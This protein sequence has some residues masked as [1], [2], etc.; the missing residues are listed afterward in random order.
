MTDCITR[1][2]FARFGFGMGMGSAFRSAAV[3][4]AMGLG[5]AAFG[6][7]LLT[8][9]GFETNPTTTASNVLN[10]FATYQ[11]QWGPEMG[12][13]TGP[14]LGVNPASGS[15]ML[16]MTD[17]GGSYTQT[18]QAVDVSAYAGMI[19]S[20]SAVVSASAFYNTVGGYIGAFGA[21]GVEFFSAASYGS[22]L[23]YS[24][25]GVL[26]L[27]ANPQTWESASITAPIPVGTTWMVFQV[28]YNDASLAGNHGFVDDA[29]LQIIP[30]PGAAV[31]AG[32][33]VVCAGVGRRRRGV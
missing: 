3:V 31:L 29:D 12:S 9:P 8:D 13:I 5:Q 18:F 23:G 4:V 16:S 19:N 21:V 1:R 33:G 26:T 27:D 10:F 2:D 20:G 24:G 28:A 15:Q 32:V 30:A 6:V 25:S 14:M 22:G 11:G 17:D 7:N